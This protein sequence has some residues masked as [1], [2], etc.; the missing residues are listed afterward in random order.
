M[1]EF[2]FEDKD[3]TGVKGQVVV[4]TGGSSGIGLAT[5]DLL[6][7]LGAS[8]VNGDVQP[9]PKEISG[10]YT[11]VKTDVS[12]WSEVLELFKKAKETYGRIDHVFAN[13]GLGPRANYI[14]TEVDENGDLKP[15]TSALLDVSLNGVINTS[16]IG[17][18]YLRQQPEGG[19]ITITGS[20]CGLQRLRAVDYS[21]AK[22][23]VLGFGRGLYPL[24]HAANIPI[25]VNTLAPSWAESNVL[26]N[27]KELMQAIDVE[28]QPASAVARGAVLV[29]SDASRDGQVIQIQRGRY[30]E[31]DETILL[32]AYDT[33]RGDYPS[34][35]EVLRRAAALE[36]A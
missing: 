18:F 25:R 33:A 13:A 24:L 2:V 15:P 19:S 16:T 28:L 14:S 10:P 27:L 32:P 4:L 23:A 6:L 22:H 12:S 20:T 26:P 9:A 5:V 31:I 17:I 7:S 8:V 1:A 21:V 30:K 3:L 35:E 34:E 36:A 11:Y 29:M